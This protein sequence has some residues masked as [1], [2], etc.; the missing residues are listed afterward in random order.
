VREELFFSATNIPRKILD[1]SEERAK[2][3]N[4]YYIIIIIHGESDGARAGLAR[5][6]QA[7]LAASC[8]S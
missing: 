5:G 3:P 6:C 2:V 7:W 4:Y 1:L 8:S